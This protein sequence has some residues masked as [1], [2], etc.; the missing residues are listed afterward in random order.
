MYRMCH[1]ITIGNYRLRLLESVTVVRSVDALADTATIVLPGMVHNGTTTSCRPN[2]R[3]M[4][5]A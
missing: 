5:S 1:N 3:A 4:Y 2:S